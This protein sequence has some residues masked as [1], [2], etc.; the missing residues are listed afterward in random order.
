MFF[1]CQGLVGLSF[2]LSNTVLVAS[3]S[4]APSAKSQRSAFYA[5]PSALRAGAG[6]GVLGIGAGPSQTRRSRRGQRLC[7]WRRRIRH[8]GYASTRSEP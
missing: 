1:F 8:R 3:W 5:Q 4:F 6:A 7:R 2:A